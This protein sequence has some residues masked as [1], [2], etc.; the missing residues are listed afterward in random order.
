MNHVPRGAVAHAMRRRTTA[1]VAATALTGALV[2]CGGAEPAQPDPATTTATDTSA[3]PTSA[4]PTPA[5]AT[6]AQLVA[7]LDWPQGTEDFAL[8][9]CVS[10]GEST[11]QGA[12]G[13]GDWTLS[14]DANLLTRTTPGPFKFH[15]P[16]T[17]PSSTT[18][19]YSN[20]LSSPMEPSRRQGRTQQ[21][22]SSASLAHAASPGDDPEPLHP[23]PTVVACGDSDPRTGPSRGSLEPAVGERA[24][25]NLRRV[26]TERTIV[27]A[28]STVALLEHGA[29]EPTLFIHGHPYSKE[30]WSPVLGRLADCCHSYAPDLPGFNGSELPSDF[31]TSL[32]ARA[33][34]SAPPARSTRSSCTIPSR[35][36]FTTSAATSVSRGRSR[37]PRRS[38]DS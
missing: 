23:R 28:G 35:W 2:G 33:P 15:A 3:T 26:I 4:A 7:A 30:I 22:Q 8:S 10:I 34:G 29:G 9:I 38:S 37:T 31:D 11:I 6:P 14:F 17:W 1:A 13:S 12:G 19:T 27:V 18:P 20:S 24:G 5:A 32:E 16:L 25:G 21:A 36:S